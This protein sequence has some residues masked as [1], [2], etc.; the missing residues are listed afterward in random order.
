VWKECEYNL[1][2]G[3]MNINVNLD[4]RIFVL[5]L[6]KLPDD[7]RKKVHEADVAYL[8]DRDTEASLIIAEVEKA[9]Q[10]R[11]IGISRVL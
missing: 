9:C 10:E 6:T 8:Q 5:K 11:G 1:S 7:L 3:E 2:K 4:N